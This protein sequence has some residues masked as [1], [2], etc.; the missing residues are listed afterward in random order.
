LQ[1][2][3]GESGNKNLLVAL[4]KGGSC[5][6]NKPQSIC[7]SFVRMLF[8][9]ALDGLI[10]KNKGQDRPPPAGIGSLEQSGRKTGCE[11]S[12]ERGP[13]YRQNSRGRHAVLLKLRTGMRRFLRIGKTRPKAK[14]SLITKSKTGF[15]LCC[16]MT[17]R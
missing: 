6:K 1:R 7:A 3:F 9:A 17:P 12:P 15:S 2:I 4:H 10:E 13:C 11:I 8:D 14:N 16:V 5:R